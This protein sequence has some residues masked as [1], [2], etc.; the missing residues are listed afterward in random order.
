MGKAAIVDFLIVNYCKIS[1]K[2]EKGRKE[3]EREEDCET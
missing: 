1:Q 2:T 3:F